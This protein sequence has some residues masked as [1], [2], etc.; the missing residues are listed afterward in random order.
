MLLLCIVGPAG[1]LCKSIPNTATTVLPLCLQS[2]HTI[3]IQNIFNGSY[4][5]K[6]LIIDLRHMISDEIKRKTHNKQKRRTSG[7]FN[8][9]NL[10]L[11]QNVFR[12][13][14]Q[15]CNK[16]R[17]NKMPAIKISLQIL[18]RK[19]KRICGCLK[20]LCFFIKSCSRALLVLTTA[21]AP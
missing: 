12:K 11:P 1:N 10:K 5:P 15:R 3:N 2:N 14:G 6:Q 17:D 7:L 16:E 13:Q 8:C 20:Y 19:G 9:E 4:I 21:R 18:G